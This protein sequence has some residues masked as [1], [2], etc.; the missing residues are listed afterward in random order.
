MMLAH[1]FG[2]PVEETALMSAPVM[3]AV[4]AGARISGHQ[5]LRKMRRRARLPVRGRHT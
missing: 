4:L 2:I 3:L 5:L 1:I